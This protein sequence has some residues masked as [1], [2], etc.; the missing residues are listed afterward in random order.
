MKTQTK[1]AVLCAAIIAVA[2][3][4]VACNRGGGGGNSLANTTWEGSISTSTS[5][6]PVSLTLTVT[7]GTNDFRFVSASNNFLFN[8][9]RQGTYTVSGNKITVTYSDGDVGE[10]E[11]IGNSIDTNN[12]FG[13]VLMKK[14]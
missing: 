14:N 4:A 9:S 10:W 11:L 7:F 8:S 12:F 3:L 6:G 1:L 13:I 2:V 5:T